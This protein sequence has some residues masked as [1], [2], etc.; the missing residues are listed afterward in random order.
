MAERIRKYNRPAAGGAS[1]TA[2]AIWPPGCFTGNGASRRRRSA[3]PSPR[4]QHHHHLA[5]LEAGFL[6]D[7]GELGG[8]VLD[9]VEQLGAQLLVRHLSAAEAQRD[10]DLVAFLEEALH[11]AHLYV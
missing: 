2:A 5:A 7:L 3:P 11:G 1:K 8:I 6:L 10:L 4:G 9:A